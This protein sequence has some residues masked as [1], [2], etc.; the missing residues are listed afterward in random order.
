MKSWVFLNIFVGYD[1]LLIV[2]GIFLSICLTIVFGIKTSQHLSNLWLSLFFVAS[3]AVFSVKFLY[4]TGEIMDHPHW[5]KIN[6][7]AGILRPLFMY[8][9]LLFL[10][11]KRKQ[12]HLKHLTHFIPFLVLCIYL[13]PFYLQTADYKLSV[14]KGE[15]VNTIG[16]VPPWYVYFQF[17]YSGI[18]L[19]LSFLI[20]RKHAHHI[21]RP[22]SGLKWVYLV[23][24]IGLFYLSFAFVLRLIGM[25]GGYNY[26]LYEM[27]AILLVVLVVRLMYLYSHEKKWLHKKYEKSQLSDNE[28]EDLFRQ[29][30]LLMTNEQLFKKKDLRVID[31]AQRMHKPEYQISQV[32]NAQADSFYDYVNTFRIEDAK[33]LLIRSYPKFTIEG[34]AQESGFQSRAS[35]YKSFRKF[36]NQTPME[37]VNSST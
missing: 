5:F 19:I 3:S 37:F 25:T 13:L 23:P 15:I 17:T 36:T 7:A 27:F 21:V 34:I 31:I 6:Y 2:I 9:F 12:I 4:A 1:D 29:I 26:Y 18:Y 16:V 22:K 28:I 32:I 35:F 30:S 20:I 24:I 8:F 33:Q 11:E 10:L 14:L